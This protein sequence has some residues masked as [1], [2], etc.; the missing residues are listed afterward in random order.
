[1]AHLNKA[2]VIELL[3]TSPFRIL[4][5]GKQLTLAFEGLYI[6]STS[7]ASKASLVWET[8]KGY[9]RYYVPAASLNDSIK[10]LLDPG[11]TKTNA[12]IKLITIDTV[13]G[14]QN[15]SAKAVLEQLTVGS[16]TTTW[17]RFLEGSLQGL[18][19]F[20]RS[21]IGKLN[22]GED[23]SQY[24]SLLIRELTLAYAR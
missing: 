10:P 17:V 21:E 22:H 18:I 24:A 3:D 13:H 8:E 12:E 6:A 5:S 15:T 23:S 19:R 16:R 11:A 7:S 2:S 14:S 4:T 1:M 9:P 20:E